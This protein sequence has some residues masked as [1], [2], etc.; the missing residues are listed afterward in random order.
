MRKKLTK[1]WFDRK[2]MI[3]KWLNNIIN[4]FKRSNSTETK[5]LQLIK[6]SHK[7]KKIAKLHNNNKNRNQV[8]NSSKNKNNLTRK[9]QKRLRS[10][11]AGVLQQVRTTWLHRIILR[12]KNILMRKIN[13]QINEYLKSKRALKKQINIKTLSVI[14]MNEHKN[15]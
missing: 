9:C 2:K 5:V 14:I 8:L 7:W 1:I 6:W 3:R 15:Q 11:M 12:F 10:W 13:L 4:S